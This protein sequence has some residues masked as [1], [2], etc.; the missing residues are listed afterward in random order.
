VSLA[1]LVHDK[2]IKAVLLD[3]EGTTTP[4]EF[5]YRVLFPYARD[6][7]REFL[8]EHGDA[9]RTDIEQLRADHE[10]DCRRGLNPPSWREEAKASQLDSVVAYV[11]WLMEQDRKATALKALQGKIWER[12]YQTGALCGEVYEDVP[13]AFARWQ[14]QNR[15]ICIYSSGSV[16][17]QKLLFSHTV[18]GNLTGYIV[19]YFDT[20]IG[21]K[22]SAESY[23]RIATTLKV[24]C[25]GAL[26]VSDATAELDAAQ[27]AGLQP[28]LCARSERVQPIS[29]P[30]PI[31]HT[32]DE[33]FPADCF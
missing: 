18:E 2:T 14:R 4:V 27:G 31:I 17:A 21:P 29:G 26:F 23:R 7:V 16:L 15:T 22:T 12:G 6:H 8:E 32:F 3:I 1:L 5:V 25:S 13:R 11:H 9:A 10:M 20:N 33:I 28:V 30:Y 24:P 19:D